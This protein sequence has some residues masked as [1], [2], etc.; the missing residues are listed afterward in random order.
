MQNRSPPDC[1]GLN[2]WLQTAE[3]IKKRNLFDMQ[4]ADYV[5]KKRQLILETDRLSIFPLSKEEMQLYIQPG[6][7][8]ETSLGVVKGNRQITPEL[9]DALRH[10][11]MPAIETGVSPIEF[12]TLWTLIFRQ[13]NLMV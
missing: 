2:N 5:W 13:E 10:S 9:T 8:L 12:V 1:A 11:I 6:N 7:A 3:L 4:Q